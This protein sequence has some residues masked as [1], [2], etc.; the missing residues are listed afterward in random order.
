M[1]SRAAK[2]PDEEVSRIAADA[3]LTGDLVTAGCL[4]IDGTIK[5]DVRC[6]RLS[7]GPSGAV[8]GN[9]VAEQA[10]LAGLV[11]G[12]VEA[13]ALVLEASARVT[14]DILYQSVGIAPGAQ[15]EGRLRRSKG[16]TDHGASAARAEVAQSGS[17]PD[18]APDLAQVPPTPVRGGRRAARASTASTSGLALFAPAAEAA[19]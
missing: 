8:H 11:D 16:P 19:E 14:G 12:A 15:V 4:H 13:G 6:G 10:R 18:P 7:Q 1:F 9:I 17:E 3:V 5:G 2:Q